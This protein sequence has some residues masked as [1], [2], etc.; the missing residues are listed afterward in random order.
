MKN[1]D[2][3]II[4][5]LHLFREIS[6]GDFGFMKDLTKGN[7]YKT[8]L[9]FAFPL[10]LSGFLSQAY[11]IIDTIIAGRLLD[12]S[13]LASI[14][15]TS[16]FIKFFS[17][18]FWGY[19]VGF[20]IFIARLFGAKKFEEL[21]SAIYTNYL[22]LFI[23]IIV[24]S[25]IAVIL[26]NP[27][28]NLLAIDSAIRKDAGKYFCVYM[29]GMIFI[30]MNSH[31]VYIMNSL[32]NSAYPLFIS[33]VSTVLHII[34]N[35]TAVIAFKTGVF[36]IALSTVIS[37]AIVDVLYAAEIKK[38]FKKMGVNNYRVKISLKN[39]AG[40]WKY[41]LP[42]AL[43]QMSMYLASIIVSPMVNSIGSAASAAYAICLKVYDVN[44]TVYQNSSK[45]LSNYVAQSLGA[46]KYG[47]IK[48]GLYVGCLQGLL[49]TMPVL[50]FTVIFSEKFCLL[51]L[52]KGSTGAELDMAVVFVKYFMPFI[53]FNLINNLFHSFYRGVAA[54]KFLVISTFVG[55]VSRILATCISV[56]YFSMNGVYLGWVISWIAECVFTLCVY[57]TG[58]WK[59]EEIR[60]NE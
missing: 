23:I 18:V 52:P 4:I 43:Q 35:L 31:G 48:R 6:R 54:M 11:S 33:A 25:I 45:T 15:A 13:G 21:K 26:K 16:A 12:R 28:F 30:I 29:L 2:K 60:N 27:I 55:C 40:S 17:S 9:L 14:G 8:F 24:F 10:I 44:A 50:I 37:A 47:N 1:V 41:S 39:I 57:F 58:A 20:S 42:A 3:V 22:I 19:G 51:F 32:G 46:K 7:I 36:G 38:C 59:S 34:G 53:L 5:I 49:F 56:N